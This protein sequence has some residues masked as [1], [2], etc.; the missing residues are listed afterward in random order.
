MPL[1]ASR[2][3]ELICNPDP[4]LKQRDRLIITPIL[5][6]SQQAKQDSCSIDVRL[7]QLFCIPKRARLEKIDC[8]DPKYETKM[9]L[10]YDEVHTLIGD[11]FV[12]HPRQFVLGSTLE[13]I[14][15][16]RDYSAY[17]IGR[18]SWGRN[19]LI[20][21]TA[22]G[23]HC[24]YSGILTLEL[25]NVGEIPLFLYPGLTVAQLFIHTVDEDT[26]ADITFSSLSGSTEPIIV[27]PSGAEK[28]IIKR[29]DKQRSGER[30]K[31]M[32]FF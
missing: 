19:G 6:W 9:E 5:D 27:D 21:A 30:W 16:P 32:V 4:D 8:L 14:H 31:D 28:E 17:V 29:F 15:L 26:P 23:V 24:G 20:I 13:W 7:G 1:S 25:T 10:Y 12:L 11:H 22:T 2:I 3:K 18:S